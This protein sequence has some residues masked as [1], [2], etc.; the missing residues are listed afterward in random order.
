MSAVITLL[1]DFAEK[2]GF[3]GTMKGV[4]LGI[5]PLATVV[6][7]SHEIFPQNIAEAGFVLHPD[8]EQKFSF[9]RLL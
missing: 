9:G 8:G 6:D 5:H 4:I 7:L 3:V 1:S 2:D